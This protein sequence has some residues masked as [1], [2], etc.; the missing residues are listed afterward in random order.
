MLFNHCHNKFRLK[1]IF[2]LNLESLFKNLRKFLRIEL[3]LMINL[4]INLAELP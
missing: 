2:L 1:T 4:D 3:I